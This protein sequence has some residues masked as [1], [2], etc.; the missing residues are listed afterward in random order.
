MLLSNEELRE[1]AKAHQEK[2]LVKWLNENR[3]KWIRDRR[4]R[5]ITTV[6][7]I[8]KV[9]FQEGDDDEVEF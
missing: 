3:I 5:A 7:A 2:S 1:K 6:S 9:L 8:E 4:G